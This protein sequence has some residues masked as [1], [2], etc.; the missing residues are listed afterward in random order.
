[1]R[2]STVGFEGSPLSAETGTVA[3]ASRVATPLERR[4]K[5]V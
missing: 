2:I 5:V 1:M 3:I 4:P